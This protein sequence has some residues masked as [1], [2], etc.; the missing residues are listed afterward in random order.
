MADA[1]A[2]L[3]QVFG[4]DPEWSTFEATMADGWD[5]DGGDPAMTWRA[6]V[7]SR[8]LLRMV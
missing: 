4:P 6:E 8:L 5:A 2:D 7:C 3:D 1:L